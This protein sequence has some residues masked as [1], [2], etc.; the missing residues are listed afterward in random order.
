MKTNNINYNLNLL[1]LPIDVSEEL[2]DTLSWKKYFQ[3]IEVI[4]DIRY[5]TH[6]SYGEL[7]FQVTK[8]GIDR[9]TAHKVCKLIFPFQIHKKYYTRDFKAE[10]KGIIKALPFTRREVE[11]INEQ[12]KNKD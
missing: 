2:L 10:L 11:Y 7:L 1:L 4:R 5:T 8:L 9:I 6:M 3:L 12:C